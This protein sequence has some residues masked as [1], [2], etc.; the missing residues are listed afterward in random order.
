MG[1]RLRFKLVGELPERCDA[2]PSKRS[3]AKCEMPSGHEG[4]HI[5]RTRGGYWKGWAA[6]PPTEALA[7]VP[8]LTE[9]QA[10]QGSS[11]RRGAEPDPNLEPGEAEGTTHA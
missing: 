11:S 10:E 8:E 1:S 2:Q 9:K 7:P 6:T 3:T 5:G 4:D